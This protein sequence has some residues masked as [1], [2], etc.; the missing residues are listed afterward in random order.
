MTAAK[1]TAN[2]AAN[3]LLPIMTVISG[4]MGFS[5]CRTHR[6]SIDFKEPNILWTV[7]ASPPG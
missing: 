5:E 1:Q 3:L 7:V 4:L 6:D 2:Y